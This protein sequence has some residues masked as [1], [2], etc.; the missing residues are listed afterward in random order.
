M[1]T[2]AYLSIEGEKQGNISGGALTDESIGTSKGKKQHEDEILAQ[3]FKHVVAKP[4]DPSSGQP[5]GPR[6]HKPLTIIK[7]FDKSSPLLYN[8]LVT[9][10]TMKTC[11]LKWYRTAR[12]GNEEHY[13]TI[14]LTNAVI[15]DITAYMP[16]CMDKN[17]RD[18]GHLEDVSFAFQ[19]IEWRHEISGTSGLDDYSEG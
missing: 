17:N 16:N 11:E 18:F 7:E 10:E 4:T 19:K 8:A 9:G 3:G 1:P 15:V 2:P 14:A 12:E 5:A 6:V 13:F